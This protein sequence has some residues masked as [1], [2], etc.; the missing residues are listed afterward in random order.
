MKTLQ[1]LLVVLCAATIFSPAVASSDMAQQ[2]DAAA[3]PA[4]QSPVTPHDL[5]RDAKG[6]PIPAAPAP[7]KDD[8]QSAADKSAAAADK[9]AQKK[10]S[11]KKKLRPH[12]H[13]QDGKGMYVPDKK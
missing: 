6:V 3:A 7:S 5:K 12:S 11:N 4:H 8:A 2:S 9:D 1:S 13:P 10:A